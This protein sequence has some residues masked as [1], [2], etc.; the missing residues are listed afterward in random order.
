M[1]KGEEVERTIRMLS[2]PEFIGASKQQKLQL[3]KN[4]YIW[5]PGDFSQGYLG[6]LCQLSVGTV[7]VQN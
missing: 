4:A 3:Y 2:M 5:F 1:F 6:Y 7:H